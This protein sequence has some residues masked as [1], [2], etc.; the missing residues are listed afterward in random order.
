M[1][2]KSPIGP[3]KV[4]VLTGVSLLLAYSTCFAAFD[5]S[6]GNKKKDAPSQASRSEESSYTISYEEDGKTVKNISTGEESAEG[7]EASAATDAADARVLAAPPA[8]PFVYQ[9]T[10]RAVT[11]NAPISTYRPVI[12]PV[13]TPQIDRPVVTSASNNIQ[14]PQAQVSRAPENPNRR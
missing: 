11:A 10:P 12:T 13:R 7:Q 2:K 4:F 9:P 5:F 14:R 6:F 1:L 8:R 3:S